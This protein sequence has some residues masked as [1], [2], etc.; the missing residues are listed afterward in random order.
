MIFGI[1]LAASAG[2]AISLQTVFN[3]KVNEK[4]GSW[5][6]TA[7]ALGMGFVF[8]L[9]A[10]VM[11]G[12]LNVY[13]LARIEPWYWFAGITGVGVVFC[14]VQAIKRLGPTFTISIVLTAQLSTALLSDSIGWFGLEQ[15]PFSY[16]KLAGIFVILIGVLVFKGV[17]KLPSPAVA[18]ESRKHTA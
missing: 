15:I 1:I 16:T 17:I 2:A 14:L 3:N 12:E 6:T 18:R 8:A 9:V 10:T 4:T 11:A 5:T 7:L 13:Q